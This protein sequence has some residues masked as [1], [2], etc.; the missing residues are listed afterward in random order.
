MVCR[1]FNRP[2]WRHGAV[3]TRPVNQLPKKNAGHC[4]P[5]NFLPSLTP[6]GMTGLSLSSGIRPLLMAIGS[7]S[8]LDRV[9]LQSLALRRSQVAPALGSSGGETALISGRVQVPKGCVVSIVAG[10]NFG[11]QRAPIGPHDSRYPRV[12]D[13]AFRKALLGFEIAGQNGVGARGVT[14]LFAGKLFAQRL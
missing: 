5:A 4:G 10:L 2:V 6:V 9:A 3:E 11:W 12:R 13:G 7:S 14:V 8:W 1:V